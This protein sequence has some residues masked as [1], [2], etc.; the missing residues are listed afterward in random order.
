MNRSLGQAARIA[1]DGMV[2]LMRREL[3]LKRA[4]ALVLA[5][6][7]VDQPLTQVGNLKKGVHAVLRDD[8]F[9]V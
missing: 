9:R 7:G 5:S 4:D 3:G 8:T 2:K 1:V 6:V